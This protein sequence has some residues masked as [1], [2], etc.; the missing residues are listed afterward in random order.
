MASNIIETNGSKFYVVNTTNETQP[1]KGQVMISANLRETEKKQV[2]PEERYRNIIIAEFSLPSVEDKFRPVLLEKLYELAKSRLEAEM[3]ESNRMARQ[4]PCSNY[5]IEGLLDYYSQVA[6]SGRLSKEA[7][8]SWF[9]DSETRKYILGK[10]DEATAKKWGD[11][12]AKLASPN[13]GIN[14]QTCTALLAAIQPKDLESNI[15]S[16]IATRMQQTIDKSN[17]SLVEAL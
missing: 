7:V 12:Y 16:A 4:V 10:K 1:E 13:H 6:V 17:Q 5:T 15:A 3:V 8:E 2:K 14:P 9:A 11:L